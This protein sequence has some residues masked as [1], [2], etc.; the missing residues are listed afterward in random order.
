NDMASRCQSCGNL[1]AV[2]QGVDGPSAA[3]DATDAIVL[4][5]TDDKYVSQRPCLVEICNVTAVKN[6]K[7]SVRKDNALACCVI[8][9]TQFSQF[10]QVRDKLVMNV[11][12]CFQFSLRAGRR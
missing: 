7:A 3:L 9:I 8:G 12:K 5:K 1:Y 2:S 10:V 4:V 11:K 6:I